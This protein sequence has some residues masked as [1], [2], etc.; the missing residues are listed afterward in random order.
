VRA[1]Q[2]T[3]TIQCNVPYVAG[4]LDE[5]NISINRSQAC[6][7]AIPGGKATS[8]RWWSEPL[9]PHGAGHCECGRGGAGGG[10]RAPLTRAPPTQTET[11]TSTIRAS[12]VVDSA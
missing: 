9:R 4:R 12:P 8:E 3:K 1:L 5:R 11:S 10:T 2:R 7:V 6:G